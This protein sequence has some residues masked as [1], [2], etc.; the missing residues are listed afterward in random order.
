MAFNSDMVS[1]MLFALLLSCL[2]SCDRCIHDL[3][4][5]IGPWR[6]QDDAFQVAP[7]INVFTI[8]AENCALAPYR[9]PS[10]PGFLGGLA[11]WPLGLPWA[12]APVCLSFWAGP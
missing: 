4:R 6:M 10:P 8:L 3:G 2:L 1:V 5:F 12:T 7:L 11:P 9:L